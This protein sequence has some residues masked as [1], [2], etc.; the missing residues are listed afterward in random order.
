MR[1]AVGLDLSTTRV[2]MSRVY[3]DGRHETRSV[4]VPKAKGGVT[5]A[6]RLQRTAAAVEE[7][8]RF[9][10]SG[11]SPVAIIYG[12]VYARFAGSA[13]VLAG[14]NEVV[15]YELWREHLGV[16]MSVTDTEARKA[17]CG[18]SFRGDD[19]KGQVA[20]ALRLGGD[21][22]ANDDEADAYVF[23]RYGL[24]ASVLTECAA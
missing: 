8:C 24:G 9:V 16:A 12:A 1:C 22:F 18:R 7:V 21:V 23:A 20:A 17:V 15:R 13:L 5:D 14:L 10:R 3:A 11:P 6:F 4:A 2:G 19:V